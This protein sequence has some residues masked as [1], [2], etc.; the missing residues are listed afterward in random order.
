[1][2]LAAA[3]AAKRI[4]KSLSLP[5]GL[6]K[7]ATLV[8]CLKAL[9]LETTLLN[10]LEVVS[11]SSSGAIVAAMVAC[12][13]SADE[14]AQL[15]IEDCDIVKDMLSCRNPL[16]LSIVNIVWRLWR[17]R[18]IDDGAKMYA[19]MGEHFGDITFQQVKDVYDRDLVVTASCYTTRR[20]VRFS[21]LTTPDMPIRTALR[22]SCAY[23]GLFLPADIKGR[24]YY[25][26]GLMCNLPLR[27]TDEMFPHTRDYALGMQFDF[28]HRDTMAFMWECNRWPGIVQIAANV[29]SLFFYRIA[30]LDA[31]LTHAYASRVVKIPSDGHASLSELSDNKDYIS[32]YSDKATMRRMVTF[33]RVF[34]ANWLKN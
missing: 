31:L 24:V 9:E 18:S 33:G 1:M 2:S 17:H 10:D 20:L 14:I 15:L 26:G 22:A 6:V 8:G 25:D 3:D 5:G 34:T 27:Y 11:G 29:A 16:D 30:H 13:W 12:R 32:L 23:P 21:R 28:S 7:A 4:V 19:F